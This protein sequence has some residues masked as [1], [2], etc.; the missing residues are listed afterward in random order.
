MMLSSSV[1]KNRDEAK[2]GYKAQAASRGGRPGEA[3]DSGQGYRAWCTQAEVKIVLG[4][5]EV[6]ET[7]AVGDVLQP[8]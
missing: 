7:S 6:A 5:M 2:L 1:Q 3:L 4:I 8:G